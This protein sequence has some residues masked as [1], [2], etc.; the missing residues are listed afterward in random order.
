[1]LNLHNF[2]GH[3]PLTP[4]IMI[5]CKIVLLIRYSDGAQLTVVECMSI[6]KYF[7]FATEP[8]LRI[9]DSS[10]FPALCGLE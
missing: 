7:L 9:L 2:T 1:M 8:N 4:I 3:T 10:Q 6:M 5:V